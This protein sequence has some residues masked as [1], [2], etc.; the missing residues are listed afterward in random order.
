MVIQNDQFFIKGFHIDLRIEIMTLDALREFAKELADFGINTIIMEWEGTFPYIKNATL[1]NKYVYT[2][3]EVASFVS[4]C[5]GIGVEVIPLQQC[6]GH[7]EYI[8]RNA[9]YDSLKEDKKDIS[10]ICPLKTT[11]NSLLFSDLFAD[12]ASVHHSKYIHIGGDETYLLG[13]CPEC[14]A[15]AAKE[16]KSKLFVDYMKMMCNIAVR[17]GKKP[18]MWADILLKYPEAATEL[19]KETIFIDWNYGWDTVYSENIKNL[20][21][22]GLTFWGAPAIRSHP[23]NSYLTC[24]EKHF[25]NQRDFIPYARQAGY[26]GIVMTSWSTSGLYGFTWDTDWEVVDIQQIRNAY[27]LSG[28]RILV[29]SYAK[30]LSQEEPIH[31]EQ[32]VVEYSQERFG[33]DRTE[34]EK[35]WKILISASSV[36]TDR[37]TIG[38]SGIETLKPKSNKKEFD[39]LRLM[40]DLW[41][42][43]LAFKVVEEKYNSDD[44]SINKKESLSQDVERL[45][46]ESAKLDH[47]FAALNKGFL[48]DDEIKEQNFIRNQ[49]LNILY[50]RLKGK[51]S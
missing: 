36:M 1:S 30:A 17:L 27:P 22:K 6:F 47:R 32:F 5:D 21:E 8:L 25:N 41:R 24:W 44:F 31:P 38:M 13:H 12:L 28:F 46:K 4:Y 39:H 35:L 48:Y 14:A 7:V 49:K 20:Q 40:L 23:D 10:Q 43:R 29:A 19:P 11:G 33:F 26:K 50:H 37:E 42:Q 2:R 16:G 15:K 3:E 9:R 51:R 45:W 34:G 18:V